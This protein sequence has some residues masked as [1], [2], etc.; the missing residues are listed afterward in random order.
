MFMWNQNHGIVQI[1]KH[2]DHKDVYND[3][4]WN[5]G[6]WFETRGYRFKT[7]ADK[8]LRRVMI[9]GA[10]LDGDATN[11]SV[12]FYVKTENPDGVT[13]ISNTIKDGSF[14]HKVQVRKHG[15][16]MSVEGYIYATKFAV[17]RI[18]LEARDAL[19]QTFQRN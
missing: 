3:T 5:V 14:N 15:E 4:D 7:F 9:S 12:D 11:S 6:G 17:K 1:E 19:R 16:S 10:K 13:N 8:I 2:E 18:V